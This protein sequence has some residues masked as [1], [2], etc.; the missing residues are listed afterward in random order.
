M[1]SWKI[2]A[3][4]GLIAGIIAGIIS[5][6]HALSMLNLGLPFSCIITITEVPL[7]YITLVELT[8][9]IVWGII[10]G[11]FYSKVY[12]LIPVK[13]V[14]KGLFYGLIL[15]L[16]YNIR[17]AHFN[18]LYAYPNY[19]I[20]ITIGIFVL[21]FYGLS[22]GILYKFFQGK[23]YLNQKKLKI[24]KH[25][26]A[27]GI[28]SGAIAGLIGGM[29]IT[30]AHIILWD[31]LFV[32][33]SLLDIN[34]YISQFG[35][36]AFMNMMWGAVFGILYAIFYSRIPGKI[37]FKGV[38]FAILIFFITSFRVAIGCLLYGNIPS[39]IGW[40]NGIFLFLVYGLLLGLLY[41]K[42]S[43]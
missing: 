35:S 29:I 16:I 41:R 1:K 22:I 4:A 27:M 19:A 36:H 11:M 10:L 38:A 12:D 31:P 25:D 30:F 2:G 8:I 42:P 23:Y 14:F 7:T 13:H 6:L 21:I 15:G 34:F 28:Q 32:S 33:E 20:S 39:F 3:I 24:S 40:G 18:Y 37:I 26:I 17:T 5:I 43:K 9:N